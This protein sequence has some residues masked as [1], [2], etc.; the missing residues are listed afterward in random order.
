MA[1]VACSALISVGT[2]SVIRF[3]EVAPTSRR[4]ALGF[5]ARVGDACAICGHARGADTGLARF[6]SIAEVVVFT[7]SFVWF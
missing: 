7:R 5:Q 6:V 1:T 2:Q 3:G 4:V